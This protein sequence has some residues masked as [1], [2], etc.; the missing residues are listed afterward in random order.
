MT[1][2][3]SQKLF[4]IKEQEEFEDP[5]SL[6]HKKKSPAAIISHTVNITKARRKRDAR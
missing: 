1:N 6:A 5:M 3:A 4:G 2:P